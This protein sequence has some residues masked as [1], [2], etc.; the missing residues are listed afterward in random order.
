MRDARAKCQ[1]YE[2]YRL[3]GRYSS[4]VNKITVIWDYPEPRS[5]RWLRQF[6]NPFNFYRRFVPN[7]T[8]ITAPFTGL[9]WGAKRKL[10]FPKAKK[11]SCCHQNCVTPLSQPFSAHTSDNQLLRHRSKNCDSNYTRD[12]WAPLEFFSKRSQ[13][14]QSEYRTVGRESLGVHFTARYLR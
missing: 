10:A 13:P 2:A 8:E 9:S 3:V 4:T 5:Y 6:I 14:A 1:T 11:Q 7:C 12:Y